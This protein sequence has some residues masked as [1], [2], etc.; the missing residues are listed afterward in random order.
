MLILLFFVIFPLYGM[1]RDNPD[2]A[3]CDN[4][5]CYEDIEDNFDEVDDNRPLS[6]LE[7]GII[8]FFYA[9]TLRMETNEATIENNRA[10]QGDSR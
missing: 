7:K 4:L 3:S 6:D 5:Y 10:D 2:L 9:F 1:T 8:G